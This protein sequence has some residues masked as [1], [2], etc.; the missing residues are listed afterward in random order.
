MMK[1]FDIDNDN[2]ITMDEFVNG[3]TK[4]LDKAKD[5]VN[6]RYHSIKLMKGLYEVL[7]PWIGKKRVEREMMRILIPKILEHLKSVGYGSLLREDGT[8]DISA[9]KMLFKEIDHDKEDTIPYH[10]LRN[11]MT[12]MSSGILPY[13]ADA[14][15]SKIMKEFDISGDHLIDEEEFVAGLSQWLKTTSNPAA[16]SER[17]EEDDDKQIWEQTDKL[18]EDKFTDKSPLAW[19]KAITLVVV[20]IVILGL[21]AEPL[22]DSV[23]NLSKTAS[24]S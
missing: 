13:D 4:W 24:V 5:T 11:L 2:K 22:I 14:A 6:K 17:S 3:M 18:I 7:K 12:K 1:E 23:L 15:A 10:E 20:E 19:K 21:L 8:P 9:I 16:C